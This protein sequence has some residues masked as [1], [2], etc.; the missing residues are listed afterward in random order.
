MRNSSCNSAR[1]TPWRLAEQ[2]VTFP[3]TKTTSA[4]SMSS[5]C[6]EVSGGKENSA[7]LPSGD[8]SPAF[9]DPSVPNCQLSTR[10]IEL[11]FKMYLG[12]FGLPNL[13]LHS[14]GGKH[15]ECAYS[16]L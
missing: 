12:L 1:A 15:N 14:Y 11:A 7:A 13:E 6:N 16:V 8:L 2:L 5:K 9:T 3:H 10:G 4:R